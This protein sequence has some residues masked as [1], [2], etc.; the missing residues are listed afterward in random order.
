MTNQYETIQQYLDGELKGKAL[1][2]F[3]DQLQS[4]SALSEEVELIQAV[5][6]AVALH[7][8]IRT[9]EERLHQTLNRM[10]TDY[11]V[12]EKKE[13]KGKVRPIRRIGALAAS[14]L[15]LISILGFFY[16]QQRFAASHLAATY[17]ENPL[18]DTNMGQDDKESVLKKG[19]TAFFAADYKTAKQLLQTI[20]QASASAYYEAKLFLAYIAFQEKNYPQAIGKFSELI[21]QDFDQLPNNYRD[22][23]K[24]RWNRLLAY[25]GNGEENTALAKAE[26][27]YFLNGKSIFYAQKATDLQ[28]DLESAWRSL[29][30]E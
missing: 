9:K 3:K 17:L 1:Q 29:V 7:Q 21:E 20:P 2:D 6:P 18:S 19:K 25:I 16:A 4:D 22:A 12:E 5:R 26:L 11:F 23:N 28:Q 15:L 8:K 14:F 24:L 10:G 30:F 13:E 27:A